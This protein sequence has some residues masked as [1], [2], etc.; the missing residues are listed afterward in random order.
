MDKGSKK[1]PGMNTMHQG[2]KKMMCAACNQEIQGTPVEK[3]GR[4]YHPGHERQDFKP[5]T[6]T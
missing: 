3:N 5:S 4:M 1:S 6:R 2:N